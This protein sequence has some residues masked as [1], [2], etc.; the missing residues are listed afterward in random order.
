MW[1]VLDLGDSSVHHGHADQMTLIR[2][3]SS[4]LIECTTSEVRYSIS[5]ANDSVGQ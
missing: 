2:P 1:Q 5:D 4:P 3:T